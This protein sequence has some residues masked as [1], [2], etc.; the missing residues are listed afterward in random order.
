MGFFLS[1][2]SQALAT[3]LYR[4]CFNSG[5]SYLS[6]SCKIRI[7][8][9]HCLV[10]SRRGELCFV[11]RFTA[12]GLWQC[13]QTGEDLLIETVLE[14]SYAGCTY[15]QACLPQ[16]AFSLDTCTEWRMASCKHRALGVM[17]VCV[18]QLCFIWKGFHCEVAQ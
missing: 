8:P 2:I 11:W 17:L 13:H 18:S 4:V 16:V 3:D 10:G 1:L 14:T 7:H 9:I 6:R 12:G 15:F 5:S